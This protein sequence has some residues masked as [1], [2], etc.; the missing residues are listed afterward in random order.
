MSDADV[1]DLDR[2]V[3]AQAPVHAQALAELTAGLKRSHWMWF[4]FPQLRG[5]GHSAMAERYGIASL[6]EARAYL[7]HPLLGPRLVACTQAVLA[8]EGRSL[9]DIFGSPDD[10]KFA[11][12]MTLFEVAAGEGGD[13]FR[14][15]LDRSCAGR[16]DGRTLALLK[17]RAPPG[18]TATPSS[19]RTGRA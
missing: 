13:P 19:G 5:L 16:R 9:H 10:L 18:A 14:E 7:A 8:V 6:A 17:E 3:T 11:S 4:V 12:S 1:F 2:F 15:A